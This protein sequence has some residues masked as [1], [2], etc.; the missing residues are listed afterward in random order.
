MTVHSTRPTPA[1]QAERDRRVRRLIGRAKRGQKIARSEILEL[2]RYQSVL[3]LNRFGLSEPTMIV[4]ALGF[5]CEDFSPAMRAGIVNA[6]RDG[7]TVLLL[8][9]SR[10]LRDCAKAEILLALAPPAGAA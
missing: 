10:E 3:A 8:S 4:T 1:P 9:N 7:E 6:I 5:T 2:C